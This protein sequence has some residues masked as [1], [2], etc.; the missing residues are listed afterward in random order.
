MSGGSLRP[1]AGGWGPTSGLGSPTAT[2]MCRVSVVHVA[3]RE[4][5]TRRDRGLWVEALSRITWRGRRG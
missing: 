2:L 1:L 3:I 5:W 4:L